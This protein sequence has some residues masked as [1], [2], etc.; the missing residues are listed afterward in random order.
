[1]ARTTYRRTERGRRAWDAQDRAVPLEYR[2]ILGHM[3]DELDCDALRLRVGYSE[4]ELSDV[5]AALEALGLVEPLG[6]ERG[7]L[8][9][10]ASFK[11]ADLRVAAKKP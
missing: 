6:E 7:D 2:R 5:M 8:D 11:L 1:M 3:G 4:A 9:F 10:T